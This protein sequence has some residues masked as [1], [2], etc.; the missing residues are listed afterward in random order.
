[1]HFPA[2]KSN[3]PFYKR[4]LRKARVRCYSF[5]PIFFLM[6]SVVRTPAPGD[7]VEFLLNKKDLNNFLQQSTTLKIDLVLA[8]LLLYCNSRKIFFIVKGKTNILCF[9]KHMV[10]ITLFNFSAA[11]RQPSIMHKWMSASLI[12]WNLVYKTRLDLAHGP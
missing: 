2:I 1:M 8:W 4:C 9:V 7:E 6:L 3:H 12:Q 5:R 10:S 11:G